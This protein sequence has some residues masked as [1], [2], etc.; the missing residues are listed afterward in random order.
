M[1]TDLD[2]ASEITVEPRVS[3]DYASAPVY[4]GEVSVLINYSFIENAYDDEVDWSAKINGGEYLFP[5]TY[6]QNSDPVIDIGPE[7]APEGEAQP[8]A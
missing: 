8:A 4:E 3:D 5:A 6:T 2:Y 1:P 7:P